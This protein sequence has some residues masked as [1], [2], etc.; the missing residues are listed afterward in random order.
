MNIA[1]KLITIAQNE[2]TIN[3]KHN[4]LKSIISRSIDGE[5]TMP[6]DITFGNYAVANCTKITKLIVQQYS[7][8]GNATNLFN[9]CTGIQE[10]VWGAGAFMG[11]VF[12]GCTSLETVN[13][14]NRITSTGSYAFTNC[15]A[16]KNLTFGSTYLVNN[17]NV[18][19]SS[20]PLTVESMLNLLNAFEDNTGKTQYTVKLGSTNLAN[21]TEEQKAIAT[22]KNIDLA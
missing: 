4:F 19:F 14:I 18:N 9:G 5:V 11:T 20:C 1:N 6:T 21:L 16:L 7:H 22:N 13:V 12:Y 10:V 15:T 3:E 2:A 17:N 8:I